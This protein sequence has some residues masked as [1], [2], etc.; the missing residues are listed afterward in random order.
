MPGVGGGAGGMFALYLPG[1]RIN[2]WIVTNNH[3]FKPNA[4]RDRQPV[5]HPVLSS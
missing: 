4:G 2:E 3:F 5:R 1:E